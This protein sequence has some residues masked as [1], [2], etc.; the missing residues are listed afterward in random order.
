ML[1]SVVDRTE[2]EWH[3]TRKL[4]L[5]LW[6]AEDIARPNNLQTSPSARKKNMYVY[7]Y[8]YISIT[9]IYIHIYTL[10][11][12]THAHTHAPPHTHPPTHTQAHR[13]EIALESVGLHREYYIILTFLFLPIPKV[14]TPR[15]PT[16]TPSSL[17]ILHRHVRR[18]N[19]Y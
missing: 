8:I 2:E 4:G 6:E 5:L 15:L 3:M 11:M 16:Y 19:R 1:T 9:H 7:I 18:Q 17:G 13:H 14:F 10:H 12:H